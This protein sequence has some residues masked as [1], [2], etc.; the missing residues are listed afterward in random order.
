M[1]NLLFETSSNW[2]GLVL[3][4]TVGL[5]MLPHGAQKLLGY[6]GGYGFRGTMSYFTETMKLPWVISLLIIMIEFFGAMGL[7]IGFGSRVWSMGFMAIMIGAIITTNF[8][9][10]L[11]MNWFGNQAGEG[12]E[13]HLLIIGLCISLLIT[14]SGKLSLDYLIQKN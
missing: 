1:K 10:G 11:F 6:F 14:G 3:R 13:Y 8:K 2:I 12:Y 4:L 5:I 7:I 9:N